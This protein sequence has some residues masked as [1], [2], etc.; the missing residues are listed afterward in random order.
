MIVGKFTYNLRFVVKSGDLHLID[1]FKL[2][3]VNFDKMLT[4]VLYPS[5]SINYYVKNMQL[6]FLPYVG[7]GL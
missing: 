6:L 7:L 5:I 3:E 4:L 2:L 1:K